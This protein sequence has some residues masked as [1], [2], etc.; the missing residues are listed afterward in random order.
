MELALVQVPAAAA[1]DAKENNI[2]MEI[3]IC[4]L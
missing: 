4:I 1:T 2:D 3:G